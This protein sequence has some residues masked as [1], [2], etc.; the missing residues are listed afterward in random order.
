MNL[1]ALLPQEGS[2]NKDSKTQNVYIGSV[3]KAFLRKGL[4]T[5]GPVSPQS[6]GEQESKHNLPAQL[7]LRGEHVDKQTGRW[8]D[9]VRTDDKRDT[10][11]T[12][13]AS[14]GH[15]SCESGPHG[16]DT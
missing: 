7:H 9:A 1:R 3:H 12:R 15:T 13:S 4:H 8:D 11:G 2:S 6:S 5:Y 10:F 16:E 14:E